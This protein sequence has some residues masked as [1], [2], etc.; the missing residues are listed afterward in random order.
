VVAGQHFLIDWGDPAAD[1]FA[2]RDRLNTCVAAV[3]KLS[4]TMLTLLA[5]DAMLAVVGC[6]IVTLL[7]GD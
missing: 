7:H 1:E 6:R 3:R 2:R 4:A 5:A